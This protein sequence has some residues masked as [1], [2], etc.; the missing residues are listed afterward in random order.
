MARGAAF[1][2]EI[3]D[4]QILGGLH[5]MRALGENLQPTLDR[6]GMVLES[7]TVERFDTGIGPDGT[8]WPVSHRVLLSGGKTLVDRGYG[9]ASIT[10]RADQS[11]VEVG[12]NLP[13][14]A[15]HQTGFDDQVTV[16][17]HSRAFTM[18]FG[19]AYSGIAQVKAHQRHMKLPARPFLGL[20]I[21]DQGE[22]VAIVQE[23]YAAAVQRFA[24]ASAAS[25]QAGAR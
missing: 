2:L 10:H 22:V 13:Y 18:V 6:V 9:R 25:Y 7:S 5:A 15:A 16:K 1:T 20:S 11:S 19:H 23:D 24:G 14:M 12:T 21:D 4:A 8:A 17:A 3:D